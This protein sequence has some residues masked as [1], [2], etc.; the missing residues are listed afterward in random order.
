MAEERGKALSGNEGHQRLSCLLPRE[1]VS[2]IEIDDL[3]CSL[4]RGKVSGI[5][6]ISFLLCLLPE[7]MSG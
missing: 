6:F 7:E 1:R 2:G 4:Q 3:F 5:Q